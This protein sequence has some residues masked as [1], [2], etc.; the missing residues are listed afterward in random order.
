MRMHPWMDQRKIVL[1]II[2]E[3]GGWTEMDLESKE[4]AVIIQQ[5]PFNLINQIFNREG[6]LFPLFDYFNVICHL[7]FIEL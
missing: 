4:S 3:G 7:Q 6:P 2:W 5:L 1:S